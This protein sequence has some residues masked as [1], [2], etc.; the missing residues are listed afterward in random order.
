LTYWLGRWLV[1]VP[2]LGMANILLPQKPPYREFLQGEANG[3]TLSHA[4][5]PF[6]ESEDQLSDFKSSSRQLMDSL[7]QP[8]ELGPAEWLIQEG[9][10][11]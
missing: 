7:A 10:L 6:L 1:K 9:E 4:I 3:R 2:F 8:H 5:S 11:G